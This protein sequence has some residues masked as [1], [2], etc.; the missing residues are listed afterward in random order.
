MARLILTVE[1]KDMVFKIDL[2]EKGG[3]VDLN[4][5][6]KVDYNNIPAEK[7]TFP[8]VMNR[9]AIVLADAESDLSAAELNYRIWKAKEKERVRNKWN[10]DP[11]RGVVRGAKFTK[12]EVEDKIVSSKEFRKKKENIN[13]LTKQVGYAKAIYWQAKEKLDRL[14][15]ISYEFNA[16]EVSKLKSFNNVKIQLK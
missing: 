5:I 11:D 14:E 16:R 1:G 2:F 4:K 3:E 10:A 8:A 12:D 13:L 6:L 7:I 9:L 15:G